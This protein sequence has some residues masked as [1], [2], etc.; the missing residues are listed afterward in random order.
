MT[1]HQAEVRQTFDPDVADGT[2][3]SR[4]L[5]PA[6]LRTAHFSPTLVA[7]HGKLNTP[8]W[9]NGRRNELEDQR[10]LVEQLPVV[11]DTGVGQFEPVVLFPQH[12]IQHPAV[13]LMLKPFLLLQS[14]LGVLHVKQRKIVVRVRP[15]Q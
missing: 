7:V 10:A 5:A 13:I 2:Q 11:Q 1:T 14:F 9:W 3:Q 4:V 8:V 15:T 6:T 12:W